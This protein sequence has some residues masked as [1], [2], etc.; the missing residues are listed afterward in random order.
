MTPFENE[1]NALLEIEC[2]EVKASGKALGLWYRLHAFHYLGHDPNTDFLY[3][4]I[5]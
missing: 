4:V 1:S 5:V 3:S 2:V